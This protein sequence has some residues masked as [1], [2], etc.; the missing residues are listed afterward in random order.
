[1]QM[2]EPVEPE[3]FVEELIMPVFR[4]IMASGLAPTQAAIALP[5]VEVAWDHWR[6]GR[7]VV[8]SNRSSE[9]LMSKGVPSIVALSPISRM[10]SVPEKWAPSVQHVRPPGL[11]GGN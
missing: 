6:S 9:P 2:F 1:M 4:L 10:P 5:K 3:R 11:R 8:S 7:F